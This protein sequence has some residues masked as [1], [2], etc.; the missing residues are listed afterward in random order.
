MSYH[1]GGMQYHPEGMHYH[2][3]NIPRQHFSKSPANMKSPPKQQKKKK[4]KRKCEGW[5]QSRNAGGPS[6]HSSF[7]SV[8]ISGSNHTVI[9]SVTLRT[10]SFILIR[11]FSPADRICPRINTLFSDAIRICAGTY[12]GGGTRRSV[13]DWPS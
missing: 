11:S 6:I 2:A 8:D 1:R 10:D 5:L 9:R 13:G 3:W 12:L 4:V 7:V